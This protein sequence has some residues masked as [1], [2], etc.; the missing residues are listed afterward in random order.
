MQSTS[1]AV[2]LS[3]RGGLELDLDVSSSEGIRYRVFFSGPLRV[4]SD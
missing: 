2:A 4:V 3:P 1:G